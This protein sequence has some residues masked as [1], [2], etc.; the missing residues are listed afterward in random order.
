M[1]KYNYIFNGFGHWGDIVIRRSEAQSNIFLFASF[2]FSEHL[3]DLPFYRFQL[4]LTNE[5]KRN[6]RIIYLIASPISIGCVLSIG[7]SNEFP[8]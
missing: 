5:T 7:I 4:L 2:P 6:T 3:F 1:I 8:N